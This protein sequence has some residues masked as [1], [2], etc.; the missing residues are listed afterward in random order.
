M[1][2]DEMVIV[3]ERVG[4]E[5]PDDEFRGHNL[6]QYAASNKVDGDCER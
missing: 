2:R 5:N 1:T 4:R 6:S 3:L